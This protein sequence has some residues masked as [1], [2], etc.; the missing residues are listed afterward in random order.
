MNILAVNVGSSSIKYSLFKNKKQIYR[1][2]ISVVFNNY[3]K[4]AKKILSKLEEKEF[5]PHVIGHRV[6][7]G[8]DIKKS[9]YINKDLIKKLRRIRE[10]APLH[11]TPEIKVIEEFQK[12]KFKQVAVFDTAFHQAMPEKA[13]IYGIP[14][15]YYKKGIKRYGFHGLSYQ[16]VSRKL[17]YN[18]LI[19]C[20]LGNGA[21]VCAIKNRKP[22][23]TSMG[24]TPLEG[25]VMA[26][27]SGNIDPAI[28][29]YLYHQGHG[30]DIIRN[31]LSKKSGL[32]GIAG[33]WHLGRLIKKKDKKSKLAVD[34]FCYHVA[35]QVGAYAAALN[36]VDA[37]AFTAGIGENSPK[38]R[39]NILNYLGFLGVKLDM[40]KNLENSELISAANSKVKVYVIRTDEEQV[41]AEE[42]MKVF[43]NLKTPKSFINS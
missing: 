38:T 5:I 26:T 6:V 4:S 23:D 7:H 13:K 39:K 24:F 43:R 35:K 32:L 14:Y 36:G 41:I 12:L 1:D 42:A 2:K 18:K 37:I 8:G 25:L 9:V 27:R 34:V 29:S 11:L 28:V 40:K 31:M 3:E 22:I 10:L 19:V 16:Y 33:D 30:I 21:S 15:K 17:R 20:H